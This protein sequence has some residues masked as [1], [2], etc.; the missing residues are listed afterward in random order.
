[1]EITIK[2]FLIACPLV[3]L[4]GFVDAIGGGGGLISLPAYILAGLP[5]HMAVATNKLS[6]ACGT[7]LATGRFIKHKLV[8]IKLAIPSV[9]CAM[10]GSFIGAK[11]SLLTDERILE[12]ALLPVL[13]IAAFF[14]LNK[15][16]F[17][18]DIPDEQLLLNRRTYV[19]V[20]LSAL[21][22]GCYDGF[23]GPGTGTFLI[24]AFAVFAKIAVKR[25]NTQSKIINLTTNITSLVVFIL[26]GQIVWALGIA[27]AICNMGG[28]FIGSSLALTKGD[29]VIR[30]VILFV[31]AL[32]AI[33]VV[34]SLIQ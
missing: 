13:C 4:A 18:T 11:L 31:L 28:S 30:P 9:I 26:G 22:I 19:V 15:K 2:T 12:I 5:P 32:L 25:A 20:S 27:A 6:S 23:Y 10:V 7:A 3:F 14:V 21:F 33:K 16:L 8:D 29:K 17:G 34:G 24:I 1:M